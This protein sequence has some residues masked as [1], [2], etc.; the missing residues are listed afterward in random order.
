MGERLN[1]ASRRKRVLE[2]RGEDLSMGAIALKLGV[3]KATIH[4][5]VHHKEPERRAARGYSWP[6]LQKGH[7]LS[8]KHGT[9]S[10]RTLAPVRE[11]HA[12]G[13]A[14]R[15]PWID[16][17]RRAVQ[18]QRLAQIDLASRWLDEQGTVVRDDEG[19]IF[20]VADKLARWLTSADT[21]FERAEGERR[22]RG[23]SDALSEVMSEF[24]AGEGEAS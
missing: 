7:T 13:L 15:F 21:W 8:L 17:A 4:S 1:A 5:D 16:S 22:E 6:P 24:G 11:E 20:D 10:E 23:R 3:S 19:R 14:E 2:L 9:R 12:A 18:A